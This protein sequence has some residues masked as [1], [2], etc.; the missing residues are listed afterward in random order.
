VIVVALESEHARYEAIFSLNFHG[1]TLHAFSLIFYSLL[2]TYMRS[3]IF[4]AGAAAAERALAATKAIPQSITFPA[5]LF[6]KKR[7]R[8]RSF[9]ATIQPSSF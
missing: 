8:K 3:F 7:E 5:R 4:C 9:Q 2:P 6:S 1:F